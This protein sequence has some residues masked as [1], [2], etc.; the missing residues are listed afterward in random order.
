VVFLRRDELPWDA[1]AVITALRGE[2]VAASSVDALLYALEQRVRPGDSVVFMSNGGFEGAP[3][4]FATW[5]R[6]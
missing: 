3:S 5:V 6:A 4:R 1:N 2:G